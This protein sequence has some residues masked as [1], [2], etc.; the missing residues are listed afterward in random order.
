MRLRIPTEINQRYKVSNDH[1]AV[2]M[3]RCA[4]YNNR[5]RPS[6]IGVCQATNAAHRR[7]SR[8][9]KRQL[10]FLYS[11]QV[12]TSHQCVHSWMGKAC[13]QMTYNDAWSPPTARIS[14]SALLLSARSLHTTKSTQTNDIF[15]C[16][17]HDV[18]MSR[19]EVKLDFNRTKQK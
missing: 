15:L 16:L 8:C 6:L 3:I 4:R 10:F 1:C 9:V 2:P 12:L 5:A 13:R 14:L 18:P 17:T 19:R 11:T 7:E